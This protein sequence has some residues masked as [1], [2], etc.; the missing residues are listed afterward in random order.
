MRSATVSVAILCAALF[1]GVANA[2]TVTLN[3]TMDYEDGGY[4]APP[5][6]ILDHWPWYRGSNE[7]WGWT[8]DLV[9]IPS[10]ATGIL[11]A[12]LTISAWDVD[13]WDG[14]VDL[15]YAN[16]VQLGSL[17]GT[18]GRQWGATTFDLPTSVLDDLWEDG[19]VYVSIDIDSDPS[20]HRLALG[21]SVLQV[22]Y[23]TGVIPEPATVGLLGLGALMALKRRRFRLCGSD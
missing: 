11:A 3:Y 12:T 1:C 16:G 23:S 14:Q 15:I 19:N 18:S 22:T 20:G 5:D 21:D 6:V 13:A 17:D 2:D 9:T 10:N 8:H 7:D 4:F